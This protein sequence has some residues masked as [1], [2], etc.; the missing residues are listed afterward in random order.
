MIGMRFAERLELLR[1]ARI[2]EAAPGIHVGQ[3]DDFLGRKDLGRVGHELHAAKGN[4]VGV[5]VRRHLRQ[6]QAVAHEI[7]KI[8]N[9]RLLII[10]R[11]DDGIALFAQPVDLGE[12]V[13]A[14]RQAGLSS[15]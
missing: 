4:H 1:R 5:R 7:G 9:L 14:R 6:L 2:L 11:Q 12:Q 10:V 13:F 3:Y 15:H 8:L